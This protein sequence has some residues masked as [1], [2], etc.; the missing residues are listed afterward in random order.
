MFLHVR[1]VITRAQCLIFA[2]GSAAEIV[3]KQ[4]GT[5]F[6]KIV[7]ALNCNVLRELRLLHVQKSLVFRLILDAVTLNLILQFRKAKIAKLQ[8]DGFLDN[9]T[10]DFVV[11]AGNAVHRGTSFYSVL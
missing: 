1:N 5:S 4:T 7:E 6:K 9:K 10:R 2:L 11:K 8:H 3:D